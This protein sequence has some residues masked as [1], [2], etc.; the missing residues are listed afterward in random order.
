M[1]N[2]R[3]LLNTELLNTWR[4]QNSDNNKNIAEVR[5]RFSQAI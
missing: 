1:E 3:A 5:V 2:Q 4:R